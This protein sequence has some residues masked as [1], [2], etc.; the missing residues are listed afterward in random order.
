MRSITLAEMC[1]LPKMISSRNV[2]LP[3]LLPELPK[4]SF[5]LIYQSFLI[6]LDIT[7]LYSTKSLKSTL[8][9]TNMFIY[10]N[11]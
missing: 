2:I 8:F 9:Q 10:Q 1:V 11:F 4:I 5:F 3:D 7:L 6:A